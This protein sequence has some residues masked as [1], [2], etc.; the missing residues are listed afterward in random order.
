MKHNAF[1]VLHL[2]QIESSLRLL[3]D[4]KGFHWTIKAVLVK[5]KSTIGGS[6]FRANIACFLCLRLF[7]NCAIT[8]LPLSVSHFFP[9]VTHFL[10]LLWQTQSTPFFA[11]KRFLIHFLLWEM[12]FPNRSQTHGNKF[13]SYIQTEGQ[14]LLLFLPNKSFSE[15]HYDW[16]LR[17]HP[18]ATLNSVVM[19]GSL[20]HRR[21]F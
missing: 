12:G 16:G 13:R 5:V 14:K 18:V 10:S 15:Y 3:I 20:P 17:G 1:Q 6:K 21:N 19:A 8:L 9:I 7:R 4:A 11:T 2:F